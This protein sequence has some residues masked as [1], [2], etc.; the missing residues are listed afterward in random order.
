MRGY[1]AGTAPHFIIFAAG[2]GAMENLFGIIFRVVISHYMVHN[3]SSPA[4][5]LDLPLTI[6]RNPP[7]PDKDVFTVLLMH[8]FV[9]LT[10][11]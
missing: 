6:I 1:L 4:D 9:P 5:S 7:W 10:D 2:V 3:S 11:S 8:L